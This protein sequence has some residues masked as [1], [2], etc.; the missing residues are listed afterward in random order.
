[1][2][3]YATR[4]LY[5]EA[6][7]IYHGGPG[8]YPLWRSGRTTIPWSFVGT[9]TGQIATNGRLQVSSRSV[10]G[11]KSDWTRG[12]ARARM[13]RQKT[14]Q[15]LRVRDASIH[16]VQLSVAREARGSPLRKCVTLCSVCPPNESPGVNSSSQCLVYL[17]RN[18]LQK[19][20]NRAPLLTHADLA[21]LV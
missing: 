21:L 4:V 15:P 2:I 20:I 11:Q 16:N 14:R 17:P 5:C 18:H 9:A 1:M 8:P 12:Q 10:P 3:D 6:S 7:S 19:L 13:D